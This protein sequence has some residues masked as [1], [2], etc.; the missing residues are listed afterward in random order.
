[1]VFTQRL[2]GKTYLDSTEAQIIQTYRSHILWEARVRE[3][4]FRLMELARAARSPKGIVV[5]RP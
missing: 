2:K 4:G 1:M 5:V 3:G